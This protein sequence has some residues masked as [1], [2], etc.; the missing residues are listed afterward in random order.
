[1]LTP[2][3]IDQSHR[4]REIRTCALNASPMPRLRQRSFAVLMHRDSIAF[5]TEGVSALKPC[6]R[7]VEAQAARDRDV[8]AFGADAGLHALRLCARAVQE[9]P[10][11]PRIG[12]R[13]RA[14][15][16][17]YIVLKRAPKLCR[18]I[19]YAQA[20]AGMRR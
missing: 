5:T 11:E 16:M 4:A 19:S 15:H 9:T 6:A 18:D 2:F 14:L 13:T 1:M 7:T 17:A 8:R 20:E 10:R 3:A 12:V